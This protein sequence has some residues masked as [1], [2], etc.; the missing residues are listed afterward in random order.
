MNALPVIAVLL[1]LLAIALVGTPLR[2]AAYVVAPLPL[3]VLAITGGGADLPGVQFGGLLAVDAS[4][5]PLLL[6]SGLGWSLAGAY[7]ADR[8]EP[9]RRGFDLCWMLTLAGQAL[10]LLG[11]DLASFYLGYVA[12]TLAAYGLIVHARSDAAWRAGRVYLALAFTGEA[13]VLS[14]LLALAAT[15]GN[16]SFA[17]LAASPP[18]PWS[19]L[20]MCL[21][22]AVKLGAVPLHVWLPLAH[23][24]AP[25]P[26]SAILSGLLVKAGLLGML[27]FLPPLPDAVQPLI[28]LG[29]LTAVYGALVGMTQQRLKTVLAYSTVSQ[30]G[31]ALA[32]VGAL[33]AGPGQPAALAAIGLFA[34]HHGLNKI[35]LFLAAGHRLRTPL[36]HAAF[37]LPAASLAGLPYTS[38]QLAK[39]ALK[40]SLEQVGAEAWLIALSL[41][42]LLTA[43]LLLHAWRLAASQV[44]GSERP[45]SAWLAAALAGLLVPWLWLAETPFPLGMSMATLWDGLWPVAVAVAVAAALRRRPFAVIRAVPEGDLVVVFERVCT[46]IMRRAAQI[47][48]SWSGL[49]PG[50]PDLWPKPA[51]LRRVEIGLARLPVAGL[52]L[53]ALLLG[54]WWM[55]P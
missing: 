33:A 49:A 9:H 42:S 38:G 45:H 26:A 19:G 21:G 54:V 22:F 8:I 20:L 15:H 12:M 41:S 1:P 47:G 46:G 44:E 40:D 31:L 14:G 5:R 37:L 24:V 36:A 13:M 23:P 3:L 11:G 52:A 34:L 4:N 30:M 28:A 17:A 39:L 16:A 32:G 29:V 53:L 2:R 6:L 51:R 50:L 55:M 35:A 10:A 18:S 27:R 48:R 25:V 7:A 43:L